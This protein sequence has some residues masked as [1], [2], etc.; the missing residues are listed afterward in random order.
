MLHVMILIA[1]WILIK[2]LKKNSKLRI[3]VEKVW[4]A[5]PIPQQNSK[6][7]LS[8]MGGLRQNSRLAAQEVARFAESEASVKPI[9]KVD[10]Q[11]HRGIVIKITTKTKIISLIQKISMLRKTRIFLRDFANG[12]V[13]SLVK[14]IRMCHRKGNLLHVA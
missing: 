2:R 5:I 1:N 7:L 6:N 13:M 10:K 4:A 11:Q 14:T 9:Y 12:A 3:Q 8:V